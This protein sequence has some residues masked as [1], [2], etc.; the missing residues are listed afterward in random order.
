MNKP[1]AR[2]TL[3]LQ[4]ASTPTFVAVKK[5]DIGREI[6]ITL[7][8]SGFPYEISADCYAV[9]TGTKPDGNILYNHCD[10]EGNTIV[11]EITEQTTAAAGRMKAEVKLYG[12]D[13]S[14]VTSA[15]FRI[16]IDG[17]V[18]TDDKVESSSEFSALRQL[19][20]HVLEIIKNNSGESGGGISITIVKELPTE[21]I[22]TNTLYLVKD[23]DVPSN[24]YT[25]YIYVNGEWEI[26]GSQQLNLSG[27]VKTVNSTGPDGNGNVDVVGISS[28]SREE[29]IGKG[30]H[31]THIQ[32]TN[33]DT[34]D[35][36]A[37]DG[38]DGTDGFNGSD[39]A[40]V[41]LW[42]SS[43]GDLGAGRYDDS[44]VTLPNDKNLKNNDILISND[45]NVYLVTNYYLASFEPVFQFTINSGSGGNADYVLPVGGDELGGVKNGG[46]V[47]INE[48]GTMTAPE[49]SGGSADL[50]SYVKSVNGK[51][52]DEK[53][54]VEIAVSD[55]S[56][57][58][59]GGLSNDAK[60]LL[61]VIL[62]NTSFLSD[63]KSNIEALAAALSTELPDA[64]IE[65]WDY[66]W[67][68]S[69][70][71]LASN[72]FTFGDAYKEWTTELTENGQLV[73]YVGSRNS[74]AVQAVYSPV[75][76]AKTTTNAVIECVI[77]I[78]EF[79]T[80]TS[81]DQGF[82][83]MLSDGTNVAAIHADDTGFKYNE[84]YIAPIALNT[85]YKVRLEFNAESGAKCVIDGK[86]VLDTVE[87][88]RLSVMNM[89]G[90]QNALKQIGTG[91]TYIKSVKYR[92]VI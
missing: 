46:N 90:K 44:G 74:Y 16:I 36:S 73:S 7:S 81:V 24:I 76:F 86:Q 91:A 53:G 92:E 61:L 3:D 57:G 41:Y 11:Y 64:D 47:V 78:K 34:I 87:F 20:S 2:I 31:T 18:Y 56:G 43:V 48:D 26:I 67:D 19:M 12:A 32:L 63:Q 45:G 39:G 5:S 10:I 40:A 75:A 28:V 4:Q 70:G 27:Y 23:A 21:D 88:V 77:E 54:N 62:Q 80:P 50:S 89:I 8:D 79:E 65:T 15:T 37:T 29:P 6:R 59:G 9:L 55:G 51:T 33:G 72:G 13:D 49:S 35:I 69:K 30:T 1:C 14:L 66:E 17:T 42:D 58:S 83:I 71:D 84:G 82:V 68:F 38:E 60:N 22:S 85:E 52:P 25:E